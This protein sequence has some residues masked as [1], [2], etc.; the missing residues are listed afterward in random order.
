ME[1]YALNSSFRTKKALSETLGYSQWPVSVEEARNAVACL[2]MNH[3]VS[4]NDKVAT[5]D[6]AGQNYP[7][8]PKVKE[9]ITEFLSF[10]PK[11]VLNTL[12]PIN[13]VIDLPPEGSS[14]GAWNSEGNK[15]SID[16]RIFTMLDD[17]G[18][19]RPP[20]V[21]HDHLRKTIFHEMMH[22]VHLKGPE[23]YKEAIQSH[24]NSRTA[25]QPVA[26]LPGYKNYVGKEGNFWDPYMG[27]TNTGDGVEIPS[28]CAELLIDPQALAELWNNPRH[29]E[30][31]EAFATLFTK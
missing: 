16:G 1:T 12:P 10:I 22:W 2:K 5:L 9:I 29:R 19:V 17:S 11:N 23:D 6:T 7:M 24:F 30:T 8:L 27:A 14:I 28:R 13:V 21:V 20:E 15:M 4:Y 31:I 18:N 25:G 3:G 26:P